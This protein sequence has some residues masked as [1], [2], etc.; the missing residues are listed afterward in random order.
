MA[1]E[2]WCTV[3]VVNNQKVRRENSILDRKRNEVKGFREA[4]PQF[5]CE[6]IEKTINARAVENLHDQTV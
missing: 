1:F 3:N 6:V 2:N 5:F 4:W